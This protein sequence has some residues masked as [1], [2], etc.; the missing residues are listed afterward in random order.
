M[1]TRRP[2][3]DTAL[4]HLAALPFVRSLRFI[5]APKSADRADDG[6]LELETATGKHRLSVE[7]KRAYLNRSVVNAVIGQTHGRQGKLVIAR[8]VPAALGEQFVKAGVASP[9]TRATSTCSWE[10]NSTGRY[11]VSASHLRCLRRAVPLPRP[12]NYCS[13]LRLSLYRPNG[14]SVTSPA[15]PE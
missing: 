12:Y 5:P 7:V 15:L 4:A 2:D 14:P 10:R 9:M 6:V 1:A 3:T 11:S 13:S 8:Y